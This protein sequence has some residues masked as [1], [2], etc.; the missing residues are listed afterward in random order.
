MRWQN[1]PRSR[2]VEDRRGRGMAIGGGLGC[3]GL[4][5]VLLL[6]WLT[7]ADPL[8]MLD[9]VGGGSATLEGG[10]PGGDIAGGE[11]SDELGQFA[12]VVL[13]DTER[14]WSELLP[15]SGT[16]YREPVLVLF[17]GQVQSACGFSSAA[18]G[19]F[20]CPADQKVYLDLTFFDDLAR[21]FGAPGDF[22]QAYVIA[23]EVGHHIQNLLGISNQVRSMQQRTD[24]ASANQLSVALELQ[25]DCLAGVWGHYANREGIIEPGDFEDGLRAAAAIGD[26]TIQR[27][28]QGRVVPE[29]FTHGSAEQRMTWLH[30]GLDSGDP[31]ACDSFGGG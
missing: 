12:A 21:R 28:G 27:R 20:Y 17:S 4:V 16:S 24:R 26:D 31:A 14:V 22:A 23:H 30:R 9:A 8:A 5:V 29:S 19:P 1:L 25:A 7:G 13:H 15:R 2:N 11:P 6:S 3:G 10:A 18:V